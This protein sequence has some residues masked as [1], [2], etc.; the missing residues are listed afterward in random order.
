MTV[1][2]PIH[3]E[4]IHYSDLW[5][6]I[7]RAVPERPAIVAGADTMSW[8]RFAAEAG[9]LSRHLAKRGL[10]VGDA[11]AT[12]LVDPT[13]TL[14]TIAER[15]GFC[16]AFLFSKRFKQ[17]VGMSPAEFRKRSAGR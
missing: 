17:I 1:G 5:Q 13:L 15:C 16:D 11:A 6:G 4:R 2:E 8:G 14:A 10:R 3:V 7:A 12:L 9:A